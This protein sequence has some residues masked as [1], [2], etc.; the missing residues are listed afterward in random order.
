MHEPNKLF[1]IVKVYDRYK[2]IIVNFFFSRS[3]YYVRQF[4]VFEKKKKHAII[5]LPVCM[6]S[7]VI[8]D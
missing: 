1:S 2:L 5:K 3:I 8:K 6:E 7:F 4:N